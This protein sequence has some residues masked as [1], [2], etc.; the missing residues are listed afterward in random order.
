MR[1]G[2]KI[3]QV[4]LGHWGR[5]WAK[6]VVAKVDGVEPVAWVEPAVA[7]RERAVAELG[8]S[9]SACFA[10]LDEAFGAVD[11]DG[12]LCTAALVAHAPT[13]DACIAAGK[14]LLVEKPFAPSAAEAARLAAAAEEAG[15]VLHVSQ[16]YRFQPAVA[17][18]LE[19]VQ[20]AALG[21]VATVDIEF[22]QYAP[23][24]NYRYYDLPD[25]LLA[26]MFI[27]QFDLIRLLLG[28]E[29]EQ[30]TCLSWNPPGS[31]FV[32]DPSAALLIRLAGGVVVTLRGSWV[33]R[34]PATAWS[35]TW[36]LQCA[37]GVIGF[38]SR[39]SGDRSLENEHVTQRPL[40]GAERDLALDPM[41]QYGR[42]GTLDAFARTVGGEKPSPL[43]ATA[44]NNVGSLRLMEAAIRSAAAEGALVAV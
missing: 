8:L 27:H 17:K 18:V 14:H 3:I 21:P 2:L 42:I 6:N 22:H 19:L 10:T 40:G 16:N 33:S 28:R 4:G 20:S 23:A 24:L 7:A 43:T 36:R 39:A 34:E 5:N 38:S 44:A 32:H 25:P 9:P 12:V 26:D 35:G 31:P 11:A 30:V 15:I 41:P 29:P 1:D 37:D 13:A